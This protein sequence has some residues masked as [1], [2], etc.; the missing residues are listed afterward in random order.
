MPTNLLH[1]KLYF[2]LYI[3]IYINT[4]ALWFVTKNFTI[5]IF[6]SKQISATQ[7]ETAMADQASAPPPS[8]SMDPY[9]FLRLSLALPHFPLYPQLMN[10]E[11]TVID[12]AVV[13]SKDGCSCQPRQQHLSPPLPASSSSSKHQAS[14]RLRLSWRWVR[15]LQRLNSA[16]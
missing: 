16:F 6:L 8:S 9:K 11:T 15:S 14:R 13:F 12:A 1:I 3:Y 2:C 4:R 5:Y 10:H 7:T